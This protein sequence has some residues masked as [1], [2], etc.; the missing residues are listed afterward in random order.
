MSNDVKAKY[1]MFRSGKSGYYYWQD[2]DTGQQ[3]TL[4]TPDKKAAQRLLYAKNEAFRTPTSAIN[5]QIA[6][7]YLTAADPK[8]ITRTW[9]E[10][11]EQ[12]VSEKTGETLRRWTTAIHDE[13]FAGLRDLPLLET[14]ADHF[15]AALADRK[16]STNYYLRRLHNYALGM[17]WLLRPVIPKRQWPK[18]SHASKRAITEDEHRKI[19]E[20]EKNP[21]RR[22]FYQLCWYL[23]GSQKDVAGLT[24]EDVDWTAHTLCYFRK[25]LMHIVGTGIKPP[26]IHF[27]D[28][29]A[30][31]L[32]LLPQSGPLFPKLIK[33]KSKDRANEFRQRCHGL[34]I[35]GVSLHCY[36]H[37]WAERARKCGFPQRF[38]QEA[39]GHNSKA[40]HAAYAKKAEVNVPSLENWE[41]QMKAKVLQVEF[42][43]ES[44]GDPACAEALNLHEP[45][46][47]GIVEEP[48]STTDGAQCEPISPAT[49][50]N[51][52][53]RRPM[54]VR[55]RRASRNIVRTVSG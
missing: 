3:G 40:V 27:G 20:R 39:L 41:R 9:Q 52:R 28:E 54:N 46:S 32:K 35:T 34:G 16:V 13:N 50:P 4:G 55:G 44:K 8:L 22:A 23:G 15:L 45:E 5:L 49:T 6:R 51:C 29:V 33:A 48:P 11:M 18:V 43:G 38:A 42:T 19:V 25:K 53:P 14:R 31:I 7:A 30:A 36:R 1:R 12:V 21:E 47:S 2:N 10:V 26:I 24:A 17:D 37:A